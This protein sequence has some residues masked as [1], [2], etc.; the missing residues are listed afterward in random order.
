LGEQKVI[1]CWGQTHVEQLDVVENVVV[2]GKVVGGDDVDTSILLDLPVGE[3]EP[4]GLGEEGL[5][6]DL[7]GPVGLVGLL[8]VPKDTHAAGAPLS[9]FWTEHD[10]INWT[11]GKPRTD[12]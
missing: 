3:T 10:R 1:D 4:L 6:G 12:D 5:L 2:E 7:V 8:E 9:V 11:H